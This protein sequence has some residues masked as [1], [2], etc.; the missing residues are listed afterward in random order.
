VDEFLGCSNKAEVYRVFDQE[1]SVPL[2]IKALREDLAEDRVF[3]RRLA[4]EARNLTRLQHPNIV[5]CYGLEQESR[6]AYILMDY[7]NGRTLRA[8]I[9]D[10]REPLSYQYIL[11]ILKPVCSALT[12]AHKIGIAHCD[13]KSGNIMIAE[14]GTVYLTDFGIAHSIDYADDSTVR[15]FDK[16]AYSAPELAQRKKPLP[17]TDVYALGTLLYEMLTGG[18]QPFTGKYAG[19]GREILGKINWEHLFLDAPLVSNMNPDVFA[20]ADKI[21]ARCMAKD[22]SDRYAD[23]WQ[24][25]REISSRIENSD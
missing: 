15:D 18:E 17:Q 8:V 22:P 9:L 21:I 14:N 12:Y 24:I 16:P 1:C 11:E 7:I 5:R 6:L 19:K 20:G 10:T 25:Y 23:V 2:A 13:V 4:R 3:M